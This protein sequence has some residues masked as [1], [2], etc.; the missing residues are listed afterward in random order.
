MTSPIITLT[1]DFGSRDGFVAAMKGV[2]LGIS[3]DVTLADITHDVPP[4]D[5]AH[6]SF[7][8]GT[9]FPYFPTGTVHLAVVDP[10]VGT[11]RHPLL[12]I[13]KAGAFIA[14]GNGLLTHV[15][16]R[17]GSLRNLVHY[18]PD[19]PE[20]TFMEPMRA[21][22]PKGSTAYVLNRE[23]YWIRPV[24]NTLHGRDI[25]A[26]VAA[27]LSMGASPNSLGDEVGTV[28]WLD[29]SEP[30]V[31]DNL[32]R[33]RVIYVDRFGNLVSNIRLDNALGNSVMVDIAGK[34][35]QGLSWSY[36]SQAGLLAITG[37]HGY[38]EIAL[39]K[40]NAAEFLGAKVGSDIHVAFLDV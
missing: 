28:V 2:I 24:S 34:R 11:P 9:I 26:P 18:D 25:F 19:D 27:H 38:L 10:G 1:S 32:I 12:L 30:V 8:L 22:V 35:I 21:S 5:I 37:S 7:V 40:G 16:M 13:T 4:Q 31:K 14:P 17:Y 29:I 33:G 39:R 6:A 15:L 20:D 36:A 23:E 3:P